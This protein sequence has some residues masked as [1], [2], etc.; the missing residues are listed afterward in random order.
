MEVQDHELVEKAHRGDVEAFRELVE[1]YGTKVFKTAFRITG[2]RQ[3]AEDVVQE[4]FLRIHRRL[5][6]FDHRAKFGTWL[7]RIATNC[8]IDHVRKEQRRAAR[9][10][11]ENDQGLDGMTSPEPRADRLLHSAEI[12]QAVRRVLD[13]LSQRER[14]AFVLRH[15]EG[16]SISE[17]AEILG[18]RGNACKSTI[19]RA[20]QKLRAALEP[21]VRGRHETAH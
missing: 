11:M 1:R 9:A 10:L 20:V 14:T 12:G 6:R 4:T 3:S 5:G 8:A 18:I 13:E 21:I 7:Y 2:N 16:R 17:I 15:Y 19:F